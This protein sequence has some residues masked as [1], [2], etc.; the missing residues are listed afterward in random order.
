VVPQPQPELDAPE[1]ETP[2]PVYTID[3]Q[4]KPSHETGDDYEVGG[5]GM[6]RDDAIEQV[7]MDVATAYEEAQGWQVE[8]VSQEPHGGFDLRSIRF[9]EEGA[10][11]GAR[12]IE[13]KARAISGAIRLTSNEW[14]RARQWRENYWLYIV[15]NAGSDEP[16]LTRIQ[17]PAGRFVEGE[18]IFATGFI[19]QE[20]TWRQQAES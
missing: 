16:Q 6:A 1:E 15:T 12:Y 3:P 9:D 7:G 4:G 20:T 11:A 8:D 14:K 18:D 13:V 2:Q 10:L 17:D 5:R 19:I